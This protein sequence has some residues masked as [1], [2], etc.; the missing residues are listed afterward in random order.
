M[1]KDALYMLATVSTVSSSR[2]REIG[3]EN[4]FNG[5]DMLD[6]SLLQLT[7]RNS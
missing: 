4:C 6:S 3:T 5:N 2:I 7:Q 1:V